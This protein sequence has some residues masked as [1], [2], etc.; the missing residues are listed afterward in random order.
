VT[1]VSKSAHFWT[2]VGN[3]TR[4]G[5]RQEIEYC[6][7]CGRFRVGGQTFTYLALCAMGAEWA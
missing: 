3:V 2:F 7:R 6:D 4:D 1:H 5:V